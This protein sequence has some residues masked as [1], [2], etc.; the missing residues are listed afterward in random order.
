MVTLKTA[1]K[2]NYALTKRPQKPDRL[3]QIDPEDHQGQ[4]DGGGCEAAPG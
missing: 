1:A 4:A 2:R 3:G